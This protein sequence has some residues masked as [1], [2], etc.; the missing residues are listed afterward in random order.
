MI[1]N[2]TT[3]MKPLTVA[4]LAPEVKE[5]ILEMLHATKEW[6]NL[7]NEVDRAK[8]KYDLMTI[9]KTTDLMRKLEVNAVKNYLESFIVEK[10]KVADLLKDMSEE[11]RD[12][13]MMKLYGVVFMCDVIDSYILDAD[14]TIEQHFQDCELAFYN[15]L[16]ALSKEVKMQIGQI[17]GKST[18]SNDD[19]FCK[20]SDRII[21][22]AEKQI[23][24]YYRKQK[25]L[26]A[27]AERLKQRH[28]TEAQKA[29][30]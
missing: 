23:G 30:Q 28:D 6:R 18:K 12:Y 11:R 1:T 3:T 5:K 9:K 7:Q 4:D 20:Y 26:K 17:L 10:I 21:K 29:H 8:L 24:V 15:T 22:Y 27:K 19:F 16:T 14:A 2:E 13:L 25:R